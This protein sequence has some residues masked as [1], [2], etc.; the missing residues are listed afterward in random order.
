MYLN[1]TRFVHSEDY[2]LYCLPHT[3]QYI[4]LIVKFLPMITSMMVEDQMR[5]LVGRPVEEY[6][7]NLKIPPE[8]Y[9]MFIKDNSIASMIAM[10]YTLQVKL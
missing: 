1:L 10:Y 9:I 8:S 3:F 5:G 2:I 6:L 4:S 7:Y